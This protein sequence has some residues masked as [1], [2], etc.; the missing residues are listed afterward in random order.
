MLDM[1]G[2]KKAAELLDCDEFTITRRINEE[3]EKEKLHCI[4]IKNRVWFTM[5]HIEEYKSRHDSLKKAQLEK[6]SP[7][8]GAR[9]K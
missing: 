8:K 3:D 7:K 6:A 5:E 1:F 2:R 4:R 9:K